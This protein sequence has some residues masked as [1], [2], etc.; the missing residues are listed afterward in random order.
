VKKSA[1]RPFGNARGT[2][3]R[4]LFGRRLTGCLIAS[5]GAAIGAT[6]LT[7]SALAGGVNPA[8]SIA[9]QWDEEIL[10]AIRIATPR[11][12]VHARNLYHTSAAMYDAWATYDATARGVFFFEKNT[13]ADVELAR[14]EAISFAAYRVL[15]ARFVTGNGPNIATI[16]ANLDSL[17]LQL[18]YDKN[19]TSTVGTTPA[20]IGNR[21]AAAI[22]TAGFTDGSNEAG[23]YAPNNGYLPVNPSMPF[24]IP[25]CVMNNPNRWQPLAFDFLV[26]QNGEIVGASIQSAIC[27]HWNGVTPFGLTQPDRNP[28]NNLYLDQG[29]P[30][31]IGQPAHIDDAVTMIEFSAILDPNLSETIDTG[32]NVFHNSP[33]GTYTQQGY[34]V[35]PVTNEPYTSNV[36]SLADYSPHSRRVVGRR[37]GLR[38]APRPLA[39]RRRTRSRTTRTIEYRVGGVGP[40]R[41]S[42]PVGREDVPHRRW[43][44]NHDAAVVAWGMKGYYDSARPIS[45]V[46]Y[47]AQLGQS[48]DPKLPHYNAAGLPLIPGLIE[49]ITEEEVAPGGTFEDFPE[50]AYE[51]LTG[52][53][54]GMNTH[55]GELAVKSWL[56]GFYAG[57]TTGV[58][59]TG[60]I[61]GHIKRNANGSWSIG[62][63]NLG[64]DDTPG[65]LNAGQSRLPR[66][67]QI[68]EVRLDQTGNDADQYVEI[69]GPANASLDGLSYIVIGD[70]VQTKVPDAQGRIQTV[71][72]LNGQNLG[73][74]GV[75]LVAKT[76][77]SLGTAD[78]TTHFTLRQIGNCT[79]AI[80]SDFT[81]Y[82]GQ[83]LDFFDDGILDV[84]P[85]SSVVRFK[86]GL[87]RKSGNGRDLSRLRRR[88]ARTTRSHQTLRRRAGMLA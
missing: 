34:P 6:T 66:G 64:V 35:N 29:P 9:R 40:D 60:P 46:R 52:E 83:E 5:L 14:R 65:A 42:P 62:S 82:V 77:F 53:P 23:N 48:S 50:L 76:N 26:L 81:G 15:K 36:Q 47:L 44:G 18:G 10:Q 78:L 68:N 73:P 49:L 25:G 67:I 58:S 55:V 20:A 54:T 3:S 63:F 41:R 69:I 30:P 16:Q 22:L 33:L 21:I 70:E 28:A 7:S 59:A 74:D 31:A 11:P 88:W 24:K 79:H 12:P 32:L 85:W 51:P 13:A 87:R 61:P 17:F 38:D 19:N 43:C 72:D 4:N 56:G 57:T 45:F 84:T 75:L 39:R 86:L 37:P 80:V 8:W 71:I 1:S 27:P 2:R